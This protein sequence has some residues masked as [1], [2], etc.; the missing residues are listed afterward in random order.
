MIIKRFGYK[1][2]IVFGLLLYVIGAICF[3]P[4]A[5]TRQFGGFVGSLFVIACGLSTLETS[6]NT[7][8][9]I[10]GSR[11][12][13]SF[14]INLAQ[15]FNGI[16]SVIAPIIASYAFFGGNEED[17]GNLDTVKWAYIGVACGVFVVALL[18]CFANIP[19]VD[20][21]ALMAAEAESSG[22]VIQRASLASPHLLLGV[23]AQFF[24]TGAQVSVASLFIF[25][26]AE[27]G[28]F[29]D[30]YSSQLLSYG[31]LCFTVGRFIGAALLR[32]FKPDHLMAVFAAGA[33]ISNVFVI[34][35]KT[36]ATTYALMVVLFFESVMF[37]SIFALA[38]KDLGRN[39]KRGASWVIM[40]VSGG[41]VIPPVQATIKDHSNINISFIMPLFCYVYVFF[42][43]ALGS[44]WIK[45]LNDDITEDKSVENCDTEQK[46]VVEP[47]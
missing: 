37:P 23:L 18:F 14:R 42:Y 34:A 7:Y 27:V 26:G 19:E 32:K 24:Y 31:Q 21:E 20:E 1:R 6:A 38:T 15:G 3:Y 8:I 35:M 40:G 11:K 43:A 22:Q 30:A 25:Y 17:A 41:A 2:A 29:Q 28:G 9:T 33:I 46:I 12:W 44:R 47:K 16:A 13:A 10:I 39:Y 36:S 45:Y 5:V 4:S